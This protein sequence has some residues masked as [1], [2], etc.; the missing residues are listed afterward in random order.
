MS[1]LAG[2]NRAMPTRDELHQLI[3]SLPDEAIPAAQMALTQ[4]QTWPPL[5]PPELEARAQAME[6]R[7]QR[8]EILRAEHPHSFG[9]GTGAMTFR[10]NRAARYVDVT[11]SA[12]TTAVRMCWNRESC[13]TG[14]SSPWSSGFGAMNWERDHIHSSN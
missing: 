9:G 2:H 1:H 6:R 5:I 13:T 10:P 11:A 3:E 12:T 7:I 8:S 4:F 14:V